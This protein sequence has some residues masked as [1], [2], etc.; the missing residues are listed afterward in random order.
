MR[1]GG[2]FGRRED[3]GLLGARTNYFR[4][5][6]A[7]GDD[8]F[9][10][11]AKALMHHDALLDAARRIH[12]RDVDRAGDPLRQHPAARPGA[13]RST[14]TCPSSAA[15]T[16]R[17]SRSG[18]SSSCTTPGCSTA[19]ACR[20]PPAITYFGQAQ[21]RRVRV[22]RR[23]RAAH[24]RADAQ[25]R[26]GA[27][28]R[29]GVP[30]GRPGGGR[31]VR[32]R[33]A[34]VGAAPAPRRRRALVAAGRAT[35]SWRR[36]A[37]TTCGTRSRGRATASPT[38]PSAT[39]GRTTPTTST[40]DADPR[41][42]RRRPRR[43]APGVRRRP[44]SAADRPLHPASRRDAVSSST[45]PVASAA[46]IAARLHQ[47]GHDVVAIARGAH[48]DAWR[49]DGLRLQTADEDVVLDV[50][51]VGH[52]S[53]AEA[54]RRRRRRA[55]DE[56]QDTV[57]AIADLPPRRRRSCARRTAWP[58]SARRCAGSSASTASA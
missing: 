11:G 29:L 6:Y 44:R 40:L 5:T 26:R 20:S 1:S 34:A 38:T 25:H 57:G 2:R 9:A 21:R 17:S 41:H 35:T 45:A 14:P 22:L 12:G 58:T 39:R 48:L 51:V 43:R 13:R 15:P 3:K 19:G 55:D 16:A 31:R 53:E 24:V 27:R 52:P 32:A 10:E 54:H 49:A 56:V 23:R 37:P 33:R 46:C 42:A 50:P 36:S 4:E 47:S 30:R 18:C 7:Y 8:V 28:H